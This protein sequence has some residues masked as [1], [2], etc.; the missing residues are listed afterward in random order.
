MYHVAMHIDIVPN[1]GAR[2]A[3]LLRESYREGAR[4]HKRTLA[5]LSSLS[6]EQISAIRA[7]LRGEQLTAVADR[8]EAI[9]SSAH[10]H[11]QAV[12][13]AMHRLGLPVTLK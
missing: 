4:V 3:Y 2:P 12:S 8:F 5:N 6:D 1:R 10:G 11:V 7:V 13:V 9:A